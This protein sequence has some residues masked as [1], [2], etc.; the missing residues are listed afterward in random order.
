M[1][2]IKLRKNKKFSY[3]PRLYDDKGEGNPFEIKHK[4]DDFRKTVDISRTNDPMFS[5]LI[6][7]PDSERLAMTTNTSFG[8]GS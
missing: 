4:F 8:V 7:G 2:F 3:T 6:Y 5:L 1:G